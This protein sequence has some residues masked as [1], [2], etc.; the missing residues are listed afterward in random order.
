MLNVALE[1]Q[2]GFVTAGVG[3]KGF[4]NRFQWSSSSQTPPS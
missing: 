3:G 2:Q 4:V 1:T